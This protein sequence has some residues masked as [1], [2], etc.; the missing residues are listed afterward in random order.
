VPVVPASPE[1]HVRFI[2]SSWCAGAGKP[3]EALHYLLRHG[4]AKAAVR[5]LEKPGPEGETLFVGWAAVLA[6]N[7]QTVLWTYTKPAARRG[8]NMVDLLTELGTDTTQPMRA[9]F[10]APACD[11]LIRSGWAIT[12]LTDDERNDL[13]NEPET[14]DK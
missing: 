1:R 13:Y 2:A 10:Y 11:G 12:Y 6:N 5:E 3:R 4:I 8:G 9:A 14:K 7:P